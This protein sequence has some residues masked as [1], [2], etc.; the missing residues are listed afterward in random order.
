MPKLAERQ[1]QFAAALLDP[2][3]ELPPGLVGPDGEP[4]L[5][6]F[7]V[8]R[9]N[10]VAGLT[11]V[12]AESF[13]AVCRIV[14]VEFFRE[15]A[16]A[17]VGVE[18]PA[19]PIML[20]YGGGFPAFVA[21]FAPAKDL[22]YLADVERVER[23]WLEAYHAPDARPLAA[24]AFTTIPPDRF[25]EIRLVLHPSVRLVQ[26]RFP[27]L[28]IWRMN[29]GDGVASFVDLER[30]GE[31]ALVMRPDAVVE[32]RLLGEGGAAF[33]EALASGRT[34]LAAV[35]A[36]IASDAR[37]DLATHLS[38]LMQAGAIVGRRFARRGRLHGHGAG[39]HDH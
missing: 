21:R 17:Y 33:V 26:S 36:A 15:M 24:A 37:F 12:L 5:K 9:N 4:S 34:V 2:A 11:A 23:G 20:E 13:P 39:D 35:E 22:P 7:N 32:V 6:R 8:Y 29:V 30:G 1:R 28:S 38:G 16:R 14:G 18:R 3:R 10:V 27:A 25:G 19:T 31:D